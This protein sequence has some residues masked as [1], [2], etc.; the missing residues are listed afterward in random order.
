MTRLLAI[1][2]VAA[3]GC[4]GGAAETPVAKPVAHPDVP[5][6][7]PPIIDWAKL[8][9][10]IK[11]VS[12]TTPDHTL[13]P[14]AKELLTGEVGKPI[15]RSRLRGVLSKILEISGVADVSAS[16]TQLPDGVELVVDVVPEP[17][18]HALTARE[19]GGA[20][21]VTPGQLAT[22]VGLPI[23]LALL[24]AVGRQ[25]RDQYLERGFVDVSVDWKQTAAGKGQVDIAI[26]IT[27]GKASTIASVEF[28][29]NSH[30]KRDDLVKAINNDLVTGTPW[31]SDRVDR[32]TLL[33]TSYYYDHGYVNVAVEGPKPAGGPSPAVF[34]ITEGDQF[35]VG[36]LDVTG[37]SAADAKKYLALI[38]VKTKDVF[39]RSA[40]V[41][42][43]QK[44]TE[45]VHAAGMPTG[46]VLPL[47][48]VDTAKKTIDL[49]LEI[50][51]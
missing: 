42:G 9:G 5:A 26:E 1:A 36:M 2:L 45:A 14:R 19:V 40:I 38:G 20:D 18:L 47:T 41:A 11:S 44:I 24:D 37:V 49:T 27:P 7:P 43:V 12:V 21:I 28:K 3:L 48:K 22:A 10:P 31:N 34:S 8:V 17:T 39:S 32:A 6:G 15:D 51:K 25:L 46:N 30:A 16:A 23:D 29:G 35:K 4:G 13:A 50:S 33:L